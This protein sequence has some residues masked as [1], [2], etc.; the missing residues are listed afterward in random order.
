M[1]SPLQINKVRLHLLRMPLVRPFVTSFG[2]STTRQFWLVEVCGTDGPSGWG[3]CVAMEE[4][5]YNE[6]TVKSA[7]YALMDWLI[8]LL[9]QAPIRHPKEVAPRFRH[10]RRNMMAKAALEGAVWDYYA[11]MMQQP[12]AR[13]LGGQ[14]DA[15]D[16]GVSVGIQPSI[17]A[18]CDL[19][20]GFLAD[21]DYRRVKVKIKPGWDL[22]LLNAL[23]DRFPD[24]PLMADANSAYTLADLDHLAKLDAFNLTMVEQPLGHDDI[25]D[26]V[27]CQTR[28]RTP[29]CLDESIHT[30]DDA[31]KALDLRACRII[32][33]KI[34]RLGGL[35]ESLIV[36]DYCLERQVPLWCGGMLESGVG[37]AHNIAIT[38]LPGF[39]LPGDTAGSDNYWTEDIIEPEV[40]VENGQVAV[41]RESGIGFAVRLD[42]VAKYRE[43]LH[44]IPLA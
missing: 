1:N 35:T 18:T 5:Y 28:M 26:H 30:L 44:E 19:V 16:V 36:H 8:P 34:G 11:K 6:E 20:A 3:E 27:Q 7:Q 39:T 31:R 2:T 23:R 32:N 33:I 24:V 13:V 38:T 17:E 37:R 10:I 43:A 41:P 40:R 12:L 21:Y 22:D 29:V 42:L 9:K 25:V 15:I 4:P 14:R